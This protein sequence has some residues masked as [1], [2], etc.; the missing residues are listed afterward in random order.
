MMFGKR[1]IAWINSS[2]LTSY[3]FIKLGAYS[4]DATMFAN[5]KL[6]KDLPHVPSLPGHSR[7]WH[8]RCPFFFRAGHIL[9][10]VYYRASSEV[11]HVLLMV[12]LEIS[13]DQ[14]IKASLNSAKEYC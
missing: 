4:V 2:S 11:F 3:L 6:V 9:F 1:E 13:L 12:L 8:S 14:F 5:G 10:A 7:Q